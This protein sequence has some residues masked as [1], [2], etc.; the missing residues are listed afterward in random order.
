MIGE[1]KTALQM[2]C[3]F[4][5]QIKGKYQEVMKHIKRA[6]GLGTTKSAMFEDVDNMMSQIPPIIKDYTSDK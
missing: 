1:S 4:F 3:G 2:L 6:G 5:E